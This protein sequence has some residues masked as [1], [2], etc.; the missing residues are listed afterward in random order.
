MV[1]YNPPVVNKQLGIRRSSLLET[2]GLAALLVR[3]GIQTIVFGRSRLQVEVLTKYL[4][5]LV[6]T[7]WAMRK[8]CA[9]TA[10]AI[11]PRSGGKLK[12]DCAKDG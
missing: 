11:C 3:N 8:K 2:R 4:K 9:A 12:K 1:F 6:R 5:D 7:C 10:A